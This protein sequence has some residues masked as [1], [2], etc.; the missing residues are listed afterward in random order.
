MYFASVQFVDQLADHHS[1]VS[2]EGHS[3]GIRRLITHSKRI[4]VFDVCLK[5]LHDILINFIQ[6][7]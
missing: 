7:L 6:E 5:I 3:I 1:S 4:M 2:A